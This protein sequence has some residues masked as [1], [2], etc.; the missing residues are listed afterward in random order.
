MGRADRQGDL[1]DDVV[2]FCEGSLP[3]N[4]VYDRAAGSVRTLDRAADL[5]FPTV[6]ERLNKAG[7]RTGTVLSKTYL[8]GVFERTPNPDR[9]NREYT[10]KEVARL[11]EAAGFRV[12][13]AEGLSVYPSHK[14]VPPV[15]GVDPKDRGDTVFVLARKVGPVV[16]RYPEWLYANWG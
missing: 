5:R 2:R 16:D 9:H 13:R 3:A 1:F 15:P 6:I 10:V 7:Y 12:E 11:A 14:L 4:S 8:Y